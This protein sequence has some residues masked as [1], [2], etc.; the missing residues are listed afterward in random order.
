[1]KKTRTKITKK[2]T[3]VT[4]DTTQNLKNAVLAK[5]L[6]TLSEILTYDNIKIIPF[7]LLDEQKKRTNLQKVPRLLQKLHVHAV[8]V[9]EN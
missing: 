4:K 1:M 3:K 9:R 2:R 6:T 8:Q 5:Q 7:S